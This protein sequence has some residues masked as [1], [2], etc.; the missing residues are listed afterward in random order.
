MTSEKPTLRIVVF[1]DHVW[2]ST[3]FGMHHIARALVNLGHK[4]LFVEPPYSPLHLLNGRRRGRKPGLHRATDADGLQI[5]FPFALIP[6]LNIFGLR[7]KAIMEHWQSFTC[8]NLVRSIRQANFDQP[9]IAFNCSP[10]FFKT[11]RHLS[12]K[13]L[14][15]R[16][17]DDRSMF[18]VISLQLLKCE[19]EQMSVY[20]SVFAS[21]SKLQEMARRNGAKHVSSLT[22]GAVREITGN[23]VLESEIESVSHPR[24][25][26]LGAVEKWFD[27]QKIQLLADKY[28]DWSIIIVGGKG[29][30]PLMPLPTNVILISQ[31]P[32]SEVP[33]LLKAADMAMIPFYRRDGELG[34]IN[35][36]KLWEYLSAGL[37]VL[38]SKFDVGEDNVDGVF[39]YETDEQFF[40]AAAKTLA[41]YKSGKSTVLPPEYDWNFIVAN[42]LTEISKLDQKSVKT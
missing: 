31:R 7:S 11:A 12:P 23:S 32:Y 8:P 9:D 1:S 14:V 33:G 40:R 16:L 30:S 29:A 13:K 17:A 24:M 35:P 22:N 21:S 25:L 34:T 42:M 18:D 39:V 28:A 5:L 10:I 3:P 19:K 2:N 20:D 27:W 37:P 41:W 26:Y 6:H 15:L 38:T 36:L 4:V